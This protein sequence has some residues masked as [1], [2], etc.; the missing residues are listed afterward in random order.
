[1]RGMSSFRAIP[2]ELASGSNCVTPKLRRDETA[3]FESDANPTPD[4]SQ[5]MVRS[6][7]VASKPVWPPW[8]GRFAPAIPAACSYRGVVY[9]TPYLVH[10]GISSCFHVHGDA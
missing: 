6:G 9:E 8:Y 3:Q 1:M 2:G 7:V 5:P 4:D 10:F